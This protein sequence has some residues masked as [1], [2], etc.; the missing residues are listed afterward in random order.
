MSGVIPEAWAEQIL[1]TLQIIA[2]VFVIIT[3]LAGG[4]IW[5]TGGF[6]PQNQVAADELTSKVN[7]IQRAVD[8]I[9]MQLS[10]MPRPTDFSSQD[11]HLARIDQEIGVFSDRLTHDEIAAAALAALVSQNA[12]SNNKR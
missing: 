4:L 2:S 8:A 12:A 5:L 9:Q 1:K 11:A 10:T 3:G 7:S 6:R